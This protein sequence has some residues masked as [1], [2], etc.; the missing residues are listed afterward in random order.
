MSY[1]G[2]SRPGPTSSTRAGIPIQL[3]A[4]GKSESV[5]T[6]TRAR[7]PASLT[8]CNGQHLSDDLANLNAGP[9]PGPAPLDPPP[10]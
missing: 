6:G 1:T 10:A 3:P 2:K 8:Q 9:P 7:G 4:G 5:G